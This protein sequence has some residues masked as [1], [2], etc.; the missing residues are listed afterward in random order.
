MDATAE[1]WARLAHDRAEIAD[2]LHRFAFGLD[3]GDADSMASALTEDC[4]F[5]FSP[6]AKKLGID[7]GAV[8]GRETVV[9]AVIVLIGPLDTSHTASNLQIEVS[10]DTATLHC[11]VMAQHFMPGQGPRQGSE[12]ALL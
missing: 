10:G 8:T 3:H 1:E 7:F 4:V 6:A 2:T 9:S 11:Y 5:D 12:N